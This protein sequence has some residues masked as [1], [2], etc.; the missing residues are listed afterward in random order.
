MFCDFGIYFGRAFG[1]SFL[2]SRSHFN[3][4]WDTL[5][6][7]SVM[8]SLLSTIESYIELFKLCFKLFLCFCYWFF[9]INIFLWFTLSF[10]MILWSWL[11]FHFDHVVHLASPSLIKCFHWVLSFEM[12][13]DF[14]IV[15]IFIVWK[16]IAKVMLLF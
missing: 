13:S 7:E 1:F 10:L 11:V 3:Y 5:I 16:C 4:W 9:I 15:S 6:R 12:S 8:I 2:R 14:S